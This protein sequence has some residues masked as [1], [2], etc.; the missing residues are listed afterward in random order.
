MISKNSFLRN[1]LNIPGWHTRKK[2]IIIESDDWGSI[3]MPSI[4]AYNQMKRIGLKLDSHY[5]RFDSLATMDDLMNLFDVLTS[6]KDKHDNHPIITANCLVANPDFQRIEENHYHNYYYEPFTETLKKTKGCENSFH[7]W[8][9]GISNNIFK[10]QSHGREHLNVNMW[11][12]ALKSNHEETI[13]A[14][15]QGFWGHT[16]SDQG[17]YRTHFLASCDFQRKEELP[18][19]SAILEDGLELFYKI[20]G[21]RSSSF[22]PANFICHPGIEQTL[23]QNGIRFIQGQRRKLIPQDNKQK[24]DLE[25]RILGQSNSNGQVNLVR[26]SYFEPSEFSQRDWVNSCLKEISQAFLFNKPA[27]ISSHRVNFVGAISPENSKR[28]FTLLRILLKEITRRWPEV[29]FMSSDQLGLL[30]TC[31]DRENVSIS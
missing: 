25:W 4:R 16:I 27:I 28:N 10:P 11:M 3:R 2:I 31:T 5:N 7:L 26:N 1:V 17:S 13:Q 14:F 19:I 21:F 30:I 9:E 6:V 23:Y 18:D 22:I 29:E 8:Q 24:Y 12:R 15:Q 20:F